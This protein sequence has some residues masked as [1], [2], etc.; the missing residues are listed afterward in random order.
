MC[1]IAGILNTG[2]HPDY[3]LREVIRR[4]SDALSHRG[5]DGDGLW[6]DSNN[7]IAL[8][9][10]RLAVLDLSEAGAQPMVSKHGRY[11]ITFNGEIYNFRSLRSEL[12]SRGVSTWLGHSDTEIILAAFDVWGIRSA[13]ERFVGMFALAVWDKERSQLHLARDRL[14]EKPLYYGWLGDTFV[15]ASEL[16]AL[17]RHPKW[18]G[19]IS[20]GALGLL[21]Q[22][23]YIPAPFSIYRNIYKLPPGSCLT[24]DDSTDH[25]AKP[26]RYWSAM[27]IAERG[28][29]R[30]YVGSDCTAV[31]ALDSVLREAV[32]GEMVADVPIGA[33]LSGGI[34]SSTVVAMMQ[35]ESSQ[36]IRTFTIGFEESAYDE[37]TH[38]KAVAAHLGTSH[39]ELYVT[40]QQAREVIPALPRIYDEPFADVSQIPTCLISRLAREQ[41]TVCL[42]G[43]GGD[44]L[45]GGYNRYFW[46]QAIWNRTGRLPD[47][48]KRLLACGMSGLSPGNWDRVFK[49]LG[50]LLPAAY[51]QR[52]PG[53]KL[54]KVAQVVT[55]S[56][57]S[58][59]YLKLVSMWKPPMPIINDGIDDIAI[60]AP[61]FPPFDAPYPHKMMLWDTLSYLPDDILAKVDRAAMA[62]SLETRLPL[63]DYRVVE[64]AWTLP[65]SLKIRDGRGKWLL[66]QVL[67]RYVPERL[68]ERPKMGF[69]V[70]ID[71]WLRGPLRDWAE[72]LLAEERLQKEGF[73]Q[74]GPIREK[75]R[76]HLT[77][78]RNW[79]YA[80]WSVLMFQAWLQTERTDRI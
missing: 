44:E 34:D 65:L 1:G 73:F 52:L 42:S 57:E 76:E 79:Q 21:L 54:H 39:T 10:R 30:P 49:V 3:D 37:A 50:P 71:S 80:L 43:D 20:R 18:E 38:A 19:D 41:V 22:H 64:F 2:K 68:V 33:F 72:D 69:G 23:G 67:H 40:P 48:A 31:D 16:K 25:T 58:D 61:V 26:I 55:A 11:V 8:G 9:H 56:S 47:V 60:N 75:W 66:R 35:A 17:R 5:P 15:F 51:R 78:Q 4:M 36:P 45:F 74:P 12:E 46:A 70:P 32:R 6:H 14:G 13:L 59:L 62:I 63:L 29:A 7:T 27:T 24:L 77:G 28:I 53:D